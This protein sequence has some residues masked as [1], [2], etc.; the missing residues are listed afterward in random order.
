MEINKMYSDDQKKI[1]MGLAAAVAI[2]SICIV[3]SQ[4]ISAFQLIYPIIWFALLV[5]I[6][7]KNSTI[8]RFNGFSRLVLLITLSLSVFCMLCFSVTGTDGY[9][10]GFL[11]LYLKAIMS[12]L[13]G[14][15]IGY[16]MNDQEKWWLIIASFIVAGLIYSIYVLT[17]YFPGYSAW[18]SSQIYLYDSKN[19][20]G[21]ITGA[22]SVFCF[23]IF[24]F[25]KR[26]GYS[27]L[28]LAV[29]S[30]MTLTMLF[31]QC[32]T[33]IIGVVV[34]LVILLLL[35]RKFVLLAFLF[36]LFA[37]LIASVPELQNILSHFMQTD[38][39]SDANSLS[40]GRLDIWTT[41]LERTAA[42]PAI[43][44]GSYYCDNFY[45]CL[46]AN[47][48]LIGGGLF[49]ILWLARIVFNIRL[50]KTKNCTGTQSTQHFLANMLLALTGFYFVE[51][52]LEGNPPLGP[53]ACS[54]MFWIL[55]GYLDAQHQK[56]NSG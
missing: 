43:G 35:R 36:A 55:S 13:V 1:D 42:S 45:I 30:F 2:G 52:L 10:R 32:R 34:A 6:G 9:V 33:S 26:K 4:F 38:K 46:Y 50:A 19:S 16:I 37:F 41:A 22:A 12:Y 8:I 3:L 27:A 47:W 23:G 21:Q 15:F 11:V 7:L 17:N 54:F 25:G 31:C 5:F 53:G 29:G 18:L 40:S 48:G 24:I 51:S 20:F 28:L 49:L 44:L 39:Y 14:L 56:P